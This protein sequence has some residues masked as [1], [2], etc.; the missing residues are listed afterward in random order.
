MY[1]ETPSLKDK[2]WI[3]FL[4]KPISSFVCHWEL[5]KYP[6]LLMIMTKR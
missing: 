4:T 3:D 5:K 2:T 6:V 1:M